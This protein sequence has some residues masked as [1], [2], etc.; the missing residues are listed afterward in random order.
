MLLDTRQPIAVAFVTVL[1]NAQLEKM[2]RMMRVHRHVH[3]HVHEHVHMHVHV[4]V[5]RDAQRHGRWQF[6]V[7]TQECW[8]HRDVHICACKHV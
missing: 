2:C 1:C 4:Y 8:S 7:Q 3:R 6:K 5:Y